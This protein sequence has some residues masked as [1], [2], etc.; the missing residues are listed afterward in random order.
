MG[1]LGSAFGRALAGGGKG[2]AELANKYLDDELIQQRQQ[3]FLDMQRVSR[4]QERADADAFNNDPARVERDRQ[5]RR[6]DALAAG[7][8]AEEVQLSANT[9]Q[10]LQQSRRDLKAGDAA[11]D[12][13]IELDR[14]TDQSLNAARRNVAADD[15]AA[16]AQIKND[17]T[18]A[19]ANNP[20]LLAAGAKIKLADPEIAAR[21]ALARA[22]A[23]NAN[24]S[25]G[26]HSAQAEGARVTTEALKKL[27]GLYDDMGK[28]LSDPTIS[29]A[30]RAK[31][32]ADLERQIDL[33]RARAGGSRG[34]SSSKPA[35][36]SLPERP[37]QDP[38]IAEA[39]AAIERGAD[40][41]K[42]EA[43]LQK[44]GKT[45]GGPAT[46]QEAPTA[47]AEPTRKDPFTGE[48]LAKR[49]W[50]RKYGKGD[51]DNLYR[52]GEDSLKSF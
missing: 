21:I 49:A 33:M 8:T 5:R 41:A 48:P 2:A 13:Q 26:L 3:A 34:S 46:S 15:A 36:G 27:D 14:L 29:D 40:P 19:D 20:Q 52:K 7:K 39:M 37:Q 28:V 38:V 42:V 22:S 17:Q 30:D 10:P 24:A 4:N 9:N 31:K 18:I 45:L 1:L 51:F 47:P 16:S 50:D 25:A 35:P 11:G 12:R 43:R 6:D 44:M 23:N 32:M